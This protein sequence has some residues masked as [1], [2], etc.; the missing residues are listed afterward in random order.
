MSLVQLDSG[1]ELLAPQ[2]GSEALA[3][4]HEEFSCAQTAVLPCHQWARRGS[5]ALLTS[6]VLS[7]NGAAPRLFLGMA[8]GLCQLLGWKGES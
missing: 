3:S 4:L 8:L 5:G 1:S 7:D 2:V 6:P